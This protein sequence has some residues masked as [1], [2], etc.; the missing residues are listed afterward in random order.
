MPELTLASFNTH[1]GLQ[2]RRHGVCEP[3]D[4]EAVLLGIEAD[5]IV[6]QESWTPDGGTPAVRRVADATGAE[7]FELPFGRAR[8]DPWP[9]VPRDGNGNGTVGL[10]IISRVPA[11][12]QGR[13]SVGMV[14]RDPTPERGGLHLLLD[15]GGTP[16]D[17]VGVHLTSRL[18]Y[19]P[20]IQLRRLHRQLP[21]DGRPA[22][23]AG[24]CNFWGPGVQTFFPGWKR[25]VRGRTWPASRPHSQIDHILVRNG[26]VS[27]SAGVLP[28]VGSDHR[29][30]RATLRLS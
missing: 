20:P 16:V 7:L 28:A 23:L 10:A 30:V 29:P 21:D 2:A 4:L 12:L 3:Y 27:V 5:V 1:A 11:E 8:L 25:T 15:V 22:I 26:I 13:L 9:H 17:L 18:P 6:V 19:G 24:D 14:A